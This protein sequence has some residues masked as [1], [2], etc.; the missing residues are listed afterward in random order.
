[1]AEPSGKNARE[2]DYYPLGDRL[3]VP[4]GVQVQRSCHQLFENSTRLFV[5]QPPKLEIIRIVVKTK[6]ELDQSTRSKSI[7][8]QSVEV[9]VYLVEDLCTLKAQILVILKA[10]LNY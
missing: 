4:I 3:T 10:L 8:S 6:R 7:C 2:L 9:D 1:M 5:T